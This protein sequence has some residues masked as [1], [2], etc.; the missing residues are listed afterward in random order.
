MAGEQRVIYLED[1]ET[2]VSNGETISVTPS[3]L[4][5]APV[6]APVKTKSSEA[7]GTVKRQRTLMDMLSGP[8][9]DKSAEPVAKKVKL[10]ASSSS[11][12]P[13]K[14]AVVGVQRLNAIPFSLSQYIES[15]PEDRR[16]LL[17]LETECMGKSWCVRRSHNNSPFCF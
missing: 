12:G 10:T 9:S 5:D 16:H 4:Q 7:T 6:K 8:S 14:I 17:K 3:P 13:A 11:S 15:I 2:T 1:V